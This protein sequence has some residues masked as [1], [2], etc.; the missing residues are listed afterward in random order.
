MTLIPSLA[1]RLRAFSTESNIS[2]VLQALGLNVATYL[3]L[4]ATRPNDIALWL[5]ACSTLGGSRKWLSRDGRSHRLEA[6]PRANPRKNILPENP[7][8]SAIEM[9]YHGGGANPEGVYTV[10]YSS[11]AFWGNAEGLAQILRDH[12]GRIYLARILQKSH[13]QFPFTAAAERPELL[14]S[15]DTP[16]FPYHDVIEY[17]DTSDIGIVITECPPYPLSHLLAPGQAGTRNELRRVLEYMRD[18]FTHLV[19]LEKHQVSLKGQRPG[20]GWRDSFVTAYSRPSFLSAYL[21]PA[22]SNE[23]PGRLAR[24]HLYEERLPEAPADAWPIAPLEGDGGIAGLPWSQLTAYSDPRVK[25]P[26]TVSVDA[27]FCCSLRCP[28]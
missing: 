2:T 19:T 9:L 17:S 11:S 24:S 25:G 13:Q 16:F 1:A 10:S 7:H 6:L 20:E 15:S 21:E 14:Y 18:L 4:L 28:S 22:T 3:D 5:V 23:H 26:K 27:S 12:R 8:S